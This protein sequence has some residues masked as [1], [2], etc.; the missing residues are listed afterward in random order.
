MSAAGTSLHHAPSWQAEGQLHL[1][2]NAEFFTL[3]LPVAIKLNYI[4]KQVTLIVTI[5][6]H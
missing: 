4:S 2:L 6:M 3:P 1:Y 5:L